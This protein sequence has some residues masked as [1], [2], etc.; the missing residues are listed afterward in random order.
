MPW[1]FKKID[2]N[3]TKKNSM[4]LTVITKITCG[5]TCSDCISSLKNYPINEERKT[6]RS[7]LSTKGFPSGRNAYRWITSTTGFSVLHCWSIA[8]ITFGIFTPLK[9]PKRNWSNW[10]E[11]A[12]LLTIRISIRSFT[13]PI[14][15][16]RISLR[17]RL[18]SVPGFVRSSS[19]ISSIWGC[20]PTKTMIR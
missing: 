4:I 17:I 6:K 8:K 14:R 13:G 18:T 2:I 11:S 20:L 16:S 12:V 19:I 7:W 5:A 3:S 15:C 9:K 1:F 10:P